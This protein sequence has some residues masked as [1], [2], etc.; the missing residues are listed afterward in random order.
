MS[1]N[2]A[3]HNEEHKESMWN[4]IS[5]EVQYQQCY[6]Y[7]RQV[8]RLIWQ[9]PA[10][11]VVVDGALI[12]SSFALVEHWLIREFILAIGL[13]LTFALVF[14]VFKFR[15]FSTIGQET[16]IKMETERATK[17]IQRTSS[18]ACNMNYWYRK[19]PNL[20]EKKSADKVFIC[21]M[22]IAMLLLFALLI[23]NATV[24]RAWP[25]PNG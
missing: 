12:V 3:E 7:W 25:S 13:V 2:E 21:S 19:E 22:G 24:L 23:I 10:V 1:K 4:T 8:L 17:I 20:L 5:P 6:E 9:I 15:Y 14:A 11:A 16:L 18:P